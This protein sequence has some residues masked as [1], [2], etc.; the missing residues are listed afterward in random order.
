MPFIIII[1]IYYYCCALY[2]IDSFQE[3][4]DPS[5]LQDKV[6]GIDEDKSNPQCNP[7][8][9]AFHQHDDR[10]SRHEK[11]LC[12]DEGVW[13]HDMYREEE[14]GPKTSEE[15]VSIYG[16]DIRTETMPPRA[17]SRR[18]YGHGSNKYQRNWEDEEAHTPRSGSGRGR[19]ISCDLRPR[20]GGQF[21]NPP[22]QDATLHQDQAV[23]KV[24]TKP[25][26]FKSTDHGT[27]DK[28]SPR[29]VWEH[30]AKSSG[31]ARW[32]WGEC[33]SQPPRKPADTSPKQHEDEVKKNMS[34]DHHASKPAPQS[35]LKT[36]ESSYNEPAANAKAILQVLLERRRS[37]RN[38]EMHEK[39]VPDGGAAD[40]TRKLAATLAPRGGPIG[41]TEVAGKPT[42]YSSQ[43]QWPLA[44]ECGDPSDLQGKVLGIDEDK[45]NPQCTTKKGAFHQH[46]DRLVGHGDESEIPEERNQDDKGS[47]RQNKLC[48]DEGVW[49]HDMYREEE[50]GPKTSEELV[51]IYGYDI[52]T[53][54]MPPRAQSRR[55]YGHGS[56]KYQRN[57]EDE[58]AHTPR[59]PLCIKTRQ[60][61]RCRPNLRLPRALTMEH[62]TTVLSK[63]NG[64]T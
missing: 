52:R 37:R 54:T 12:R 24:P 47:R 46:D 11:K 30:V 59:M 34:S 18:L 4:G 62:Q 63:E 44:E 64:S 2:A 61:S 50:Q 17:Q 13:S 27:P 21:G 8:K 49:S 36:A 39:T 3:S 48:R 42:H 41:G 23:V 57:W 19:G 14:Q 55:L 7:K 9:R 51:S 29:Q 45:S 1:I 6:L 22:F 10:G 60:W 56:N 40:L 25:A 26:A 43:R 53:E 38:A 5:D 35:P 31:T 20:G 58:E 33:P 16:Y 32:D 15:L 28:H